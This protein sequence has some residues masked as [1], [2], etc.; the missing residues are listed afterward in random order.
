[1][2]STLRA[3]LREAAFFFLGFCAIAVPLRIVWLSL[4]SAGAAPFFYAIGPSDVAAGCIVTIAWLLGAGLLPRRALRLALGAILLA[5]SG[6]LLI[7]SAR[8]YFTYE[9]PFR[10]SHLTHVEGA[11]QMTQSITAELNGAILMGAAAVIVSAVGWALAASRLPFLR[12]SSSAEEISI[13]RRSSAAL[14]AATIVLVV[15]GLAHALDRA[16]LSNERGYNL[17]HQLLVGEAPVRNR[18]IQLAAASRA[19]NADLTRP[20][21][22]DS[23]ADPS[24]L[25]R[26]SI[27]V[28]KQQYNIVIYLFEGTSFEYIGQQVN[29]RSITPNWD[30]LALHSLSM[31]NHHASNPLTVNALFSL[32]TSA[33]PLPADR[34]AIKDLPGIA[35][36]SLPQALRQ[37][38]YRTGIV[39]TGYF[40]YARQEN[41][42]R[43]RFDLVLD[44]N[45]LRKPPY[46]YTLNW[47]ID[48][49]ALIAPALEFARKDATRPFFLLLKPETPHHPY[50]VPED[51]FVVERPQNASGSRAKSLAKYR[52]ALFFAD[53][54]MGEAIHSFEQQG[55]SDNTLFFIIADHGEAFGQHRGNY[56]HPFYVYQENVHVPFLIYNRRVFPKRRDLK[57]VTRH[58]DVAVTILDLLGLPS[59]PEYQGRSFVRA[60]RPQ[61]A[62]FNTTWR[63]DLSGLRDGR[64]KYIYNVRSG[65]AE[66]YDLTT[67]PHETRNLA[68]EQP[69]LVADYQTKLVAFRAH[70]R[71]WYE[72]VVGRSID[73]TVTMSKDGL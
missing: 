72:R 11:S 45:Q 14:A 15:L 65:S 24:L 70:Q 40:K 9:T 50:D 49:R 18:R 33:F 28:G 56:N 62:F 48:D 5:L 60:G 4:S 59:P 41:F 35:V 43:H 57:R 13:R 68:Q 63:N 36:N 34:W 44:V 19:A 17:I 25:P 39:N 12:E 23:L 46:T 29:G 7:A 51:R 38:G 21:S 53:H 42:L 22:A 67:D 2:S 55:L 66:L 20:F 64:W 16:A 8:Y 58:E 52:N 30:R 61:M 47:G 10:L 73:W 3:T 6:I 26:V 32:L 1:M 31:L 27:P 54:V 37:A 71:A 69:Q